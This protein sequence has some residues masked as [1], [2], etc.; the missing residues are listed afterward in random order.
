MTRPPRPRCI[1]VCRQRA[2]MRASGNVNWGQQIYMPAARHTCMP[3]S[4]TLVT[5]RARTTEDLHR[6][7]RLAPC[8][9]HR[10]EPPRVHRV[11]AGEQLPPPAPCPSQAE[12][13]TVT[14]D[15]VCVIVWRW[16]MEV[17]GQQR[18]CMPAH[19]VACGQQGA[20][21]RQK[22]RVAG[23]AWAQHTAM[24]AAARREDPPHPAPRIIRVCIGS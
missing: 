22:T 19:G 12:D 11:C 16:A 18:T 5:G 23:H 4:G 8:D 10:E 17:K 2:W 6:G 1:V 14:P 20:R 15:I 24:S 9:V 7:A 3:M 21:A 13:T